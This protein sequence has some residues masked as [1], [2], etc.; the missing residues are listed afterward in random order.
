MILAS[1]VPLWLGCCPKS[2]DEAREPEGC[3]GGLWL[4]DVP[5]PPN[6]SSP[7][8]KFPHRDLNPGLS[9]ERRLS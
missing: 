9:R 4:C 2:E 6:E 8:K 5:H 7:P 1:E 3:Q